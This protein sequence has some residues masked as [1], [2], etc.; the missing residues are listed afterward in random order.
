M[1]VK[2]DFCLNHQFGVV[3][4]I[5][6]RFVLSGHGKISEYPRVLPIFS[7]SVITNAIVHLVNQQIL[8]MN[9]EAGVLSISEPIK[10]LIIA[11]Q[12]NEYE[13][14]IPSSIE[15]EMNSDG[16]VLSGNDV[17]ALQN[18]DL[19]IRELLPSIK[20]DFLVGSLDFRIHK[21]EEDT[22]K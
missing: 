8:S 6:F 9:T 3:E 1:K 2:I 21:K 14:I 13:I 15:K 16:I 19:V 5:I 18:K 10:A 20:L 17:E 11:C 12:E 7:D 22:L 4:R